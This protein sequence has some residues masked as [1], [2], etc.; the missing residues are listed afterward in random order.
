MKQSEILEWLSRIQKKI[1]EVQDDMAYLNEFVPILNKLGEDLSLIDKAV[2]Q[3]PLDYQNLLIED[4]WDSL[5]HTEQKVDDIRDKIPYKSEL[6]PLLPSTNSTG[7]INVYWFNESLNQNYEKFSYDPQYIK[8]INDNWNPYYEE[9]K[10][11]LDITKIVKHILAQIDQNLF[12]LHSKATK[13][14]N[15][16][17]AN[18]LSTSNAASSLRT[19]L[20]KYKGFLKNKCKG[21]KP[22]NQ[23]YRLIA[24]EL[25]IDFGSFHTTIVDGQE[26]Y[27]KI[28]SELTD[29][30]KENLQVQPKRI[31]ELLSMIE[32]HI[33]VISSSLDPQKTGLKFLR[34]RLIS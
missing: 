5:Q 15:L 7:T 16:C 24:D 6:I 28:W 2:G 14:V 27:N 22:K 17:I 10:N 25:S 18:Q 34:L 30:F 1:N 31:K 29:I 8:F 26:K 9:Y 3:I 4:F 20:E 21:Q 19:L 11:K 32:Y 12:D 13:H 33:F 23:I